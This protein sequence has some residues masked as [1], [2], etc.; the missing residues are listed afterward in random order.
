VLYKL[1]NNAVLPI[2]QY[3]KWLR[4]V[5]WLNSFWRAFW[6]SFAKIRSNKL[7]RINWT[8]YDRSVTVLLWLIVYS[9][10]S[11]FSSIQQLSPLP[12]TATD[13]ILCLVLMAFSSEGSFMCHTCCA[14]GPRFI[15]YLK[16]R[17]PHIPRRDWKQRNDHQI[18]LQPPITTVLLRATFFKMNT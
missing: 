9:C 2:H 13:L 17:F 12:V 3:C 5:L 16:D 8:I 10:L 14:T 1:N 11:I 6:L 4:I 18:F 15:C 7:S